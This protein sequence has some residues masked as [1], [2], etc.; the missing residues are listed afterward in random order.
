MTTVQVKPIKATPFVDSPPYAAERGNLTAKQL[1]VLRCAR[2]LERGF[3]EFAGLSQI[4]LSV[5]EVIKTN[6]NE[7]RTSIIKECLSKTPD[8]N[9]VDTIRQLGRLV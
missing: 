2:R 4:P 3:W 9:M 8:H 7:S 5:G 1:Q 6:V